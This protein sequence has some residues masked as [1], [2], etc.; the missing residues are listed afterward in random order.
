MAG[1]LGPVCWAGTIL[2]IS[3]SI[4]YAAGRYI[5]VT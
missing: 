1:P 5:G 2:T 3:A 4:T